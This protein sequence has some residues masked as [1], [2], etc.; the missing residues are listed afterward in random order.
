MSQ[1][2]PSRSEREGISCVKLM[3]MFP[4]DETSRKW[5]ENKVWPNG[6]FCPHCGSV[7][8]QEQ[9]TH[10]SMTHRCR[11]CPNRPMFSLRT[12][13][14]MQG[15]KLGYQTWVIAIYLV[16]TSLKGVSSMKLHRD[17]EI[18]QKSAW[19]LAHRLRKAFEIGIPVFAGSV[20]A[21]KTYMSGK[22]KNK[23][24]N[25]KLRAGRGAVNKTAVAGVKDRAS[26]KVV[27]K[28]VEKTDAK[29]LQDLVT[30]HTEE[31]AT[32]YT[33]KAVAYKGI[34]RTHEAVNRDMAHTNGLESFWAGKRSHDGVYKMSPK[35]L[36]RY[37]SEFIGRHNMC[38]VGTESQMGLI[39]GKMVGKRLRYRE[40]IA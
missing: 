29:T 28:V 25:K 30:D 3:K 39:V 8:V 35:H 24:S 12:G 36:N 20:E 13:N 4:D 1:K 32:I 34:K 18:T 31:T 5:F 6:A 40:L 16:T 17:L 15:T 33:D 37:I 27:A 14:V 22:E 21:D 7:N 10:K 19:H 2:A 23:H 11:D 26:G 38:P 9:T